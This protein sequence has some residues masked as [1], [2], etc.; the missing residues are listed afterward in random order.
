[1][2]GDHDDDF[3]Q[4][5][6]SLA[7]VVTSARE[8]KEE[9]YHDRL[10]EACIGQ[11][12]TVVRG[13]FIV[14]NICLDVRGAQAL[15]LLELVAAGYQPDV[16]MLTT[17]GFHVE[18][19]D[20]EESPDDL[21]EAFHEGDLR[22]GEALFTVATHRRHPASLL[23]LAPFRLQDDGS[24]EWLTLRRVVMDPSCDCGCGTA[25]QENGSG[26]AAAVTAARR[27]LSQPELFLLLQQRLGVEPPLREIPDDPAQ[28]QTLM[29][30]VTSVWL[31]QQT[32]ADTDLVAHHDFMPP[33][34]VERVLSTEALDE[35]V[36]L[37][38]E[39]ING[40]D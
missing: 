34:M 13:D 1:M 36:G 15:A 3:R 20:D 2:R 32:A 8:Y 22:I 10:P 28:R 21:F 14:A 24:L 38:E 39:E 9:T 19:G 11:V 33:E 18:L 35:L 40:G 25:A 31:E 7:A 17:E 29:D 37:L 16:L 5:E 30:N 12:I 23:S 26:V 6:A 27:G 4:M